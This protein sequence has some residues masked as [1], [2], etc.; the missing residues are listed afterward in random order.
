MQILCDKRNV[1]YENL[2]K[3]VY[4]LLFFH[5]IVLY[6][7]LKCVLHAKC[8]EDLKKKGKPSDDFEYGF[9]SRYISHV[10]Q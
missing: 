4:T 2:R 8:M 1:I 10:F 9:Y 3:Q 6:D 5:I 7:T